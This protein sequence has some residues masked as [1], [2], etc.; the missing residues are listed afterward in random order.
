MLVAAALAV[1]LASC[2]S[3]KNYANNPR[4]A[5]PIVVAAAVSPNAISVS[6]SSFGAGLIQLVVTNLTTSSQQLEI[7]SKPGS[8]ARAF[9]QET[10][11]INPQDTATLKADVGRGSYTVRVTGAGGAIKSATIS[12][13]P[14]RT[15]SQN[16]LLQP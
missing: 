6:P 4:P 3:T 8:G 1:L 16:Q 12:V 14:P 2:G 13:G 7:T 10:G 11:P 5:E 15:S 9:R